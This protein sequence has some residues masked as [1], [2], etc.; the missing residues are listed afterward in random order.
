VRFAAKDTAPRPVPHCHVRRV[1]RLVAV[2]I[3]TFPQPREKP[4]RHARVSAEHR[5][6]LLE[7][8]RER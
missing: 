6:I 8:T 1:L 2:A 5:R 3:A 7:N 4:R